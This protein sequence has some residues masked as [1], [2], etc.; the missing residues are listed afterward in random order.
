MTYTKSLHKTLKKKNQTKLFGQ[1]LK[2][3]RENHEIG[4]YLVVKVVLIKP[5]HLASSD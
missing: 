3:K 2:L 5:R 1:K 4:K